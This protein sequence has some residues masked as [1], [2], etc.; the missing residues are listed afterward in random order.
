[1]ELREKILDEA[2]KLFIRNGI[3]VV[4]MDSIAQSLGI[5]KR[6]IYENFKDKNDLLRTFLV[7]SAL[8]HKNK[9][10]EIIKESNNVIEAIFKFGEFNRKIFSMINPLFFEDIKKYHN[11]LFEG[12]MN[13]EHIRNY[14]IS[15]TL[16]K[17]GVNEG[18]F[19]K[20]LDIEIANLFLHNTM[21]FFHKIDKNKS[22]DH[23]KIWNSIFLPYIKGISTEKGLALLNSFL[24]THENFYCNQSLENTA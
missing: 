2:G 23:I 14:E 24:D 16:L 15:Y 17:K 19:I 9:L 20:N 5:S 11:E 1:V 8:S 6:T 21:D 7:I 4:T 13:S 10:L 3:R 22:I 12:V 18:V